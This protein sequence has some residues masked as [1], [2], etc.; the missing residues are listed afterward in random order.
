MAQRELQQHTSCESAH[1]RTNSVHTE[2]LRAAGQGITHA[3]ANSRGVQKEPRGGEPQAAPAGEPATPRSRY[4]LLAR[5]SDVEMPITVCISL[6]L[7]R[8]ASEPP[9]AG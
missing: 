2:V 4:P 9:V 7:P 3:L 8:L 6:R 5:Q 1:R